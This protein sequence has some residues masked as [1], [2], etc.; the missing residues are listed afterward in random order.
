MTER[1]VERR[2]EATRD[3]KET[4]ITVVMDLDLSLIH[5]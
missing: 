2:A 1:I 5:I 3:T 4:Q